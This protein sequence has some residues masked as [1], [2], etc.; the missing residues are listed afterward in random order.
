MHLYIRPKRLAAYAG[1]QDHMNVEVWIFIVEKYLKKVQLEATV[2]LP[3]NDRM[4][5]AAAMLSVCA[6]SC[7]FVM[8]QS[9]QV[10][11]T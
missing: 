4:R 11:P 6:E 7:C 9:N 10:S 5:F 8:V 2:V 1:K 3:D